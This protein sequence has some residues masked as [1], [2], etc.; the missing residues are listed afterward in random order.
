MTRL[1]SRMAVLA[2]IAALAYAA[3]LA[4]ASDESRICAQVV[5]FVEGF[6]EGNLGDCLDVLDPE[7]RD[8]SVSE[9]DGEM[10]RRALS[11]IFLT[12]MQSAKTGKDL[13]MVVPQEGIQVLI[14]EGAERA[15]V[16]FEA[17]V[18]RGAKEDW[19]TV[20]K[21]RVEADA[22]NTDGEWL[23]YRTRHTTLEGTRPR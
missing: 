4:M 15:S 3:V 11:Y 23:L 10:M 1:L 7:Y 5:S 9:L 20:W 6:N 22:R 13:R 8:E 18:Q 17:A 12:R 2:T 14:E 19:K 21:I 16:E